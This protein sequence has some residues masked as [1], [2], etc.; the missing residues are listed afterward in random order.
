M[1]A[2]LTYADGRCDARECEVATSFYRR[3]MGLMGRGS[4][5]P[6]H[7]MA[8]PRCSSIHMFFMR[9]PID[10]IW[11]KGDD[12]IKVTHSLPQWHLDGCRGADMCVECAAETVG[13][14]LVSVVIEP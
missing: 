9:F 1:R 4:I 13:D 8:F 5:E 14:G 11:A 3:F 2:V 10:V 12:V 7:C 6:T